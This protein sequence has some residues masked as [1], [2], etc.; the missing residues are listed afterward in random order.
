MEEFHLP[1]WD[2]KKNFAKYVKQ[3]VNVPYQP[4]QNFF[5]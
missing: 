4:V 3:W 5:Q 2:A 1:S